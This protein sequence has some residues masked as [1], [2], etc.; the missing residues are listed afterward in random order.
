MKNSFNAPDYLN[1]IGYI[2]SPP[3]VS[4]DTLNELHQRHLFTV[5]FENLD[6]HLK[7]EISL[8]IDQSFNKVAPSRRGG[9]CYEVNNLFHHLLKALGFELYFI[10]SMVGTG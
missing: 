1:R 3:E 10:S 8:D 2:G 9:F 5:P 6:V 4:I 7:R